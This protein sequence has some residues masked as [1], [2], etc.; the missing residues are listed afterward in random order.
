MTPE[1][2][3]VGALVIILLTVLAIAWLAFHPEFGVP[4]ERPRLPLEAPRLIS[5]WRRS[6]GDPGE[7]ET[8]IERRF[9]GYR[10]G[11]AII[12]SQPMTIIDLSHRSRR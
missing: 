6:D 12:L 9:Q 7:I 2:T 3:I 5:S 11:E 8:E 10:R 1:Q 4:P